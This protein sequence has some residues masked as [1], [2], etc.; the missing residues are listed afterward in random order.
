MCWI[1]YRGEGMIR[2]TRFNGEIYFINAELIQ[3]VEATPDTIITLVNHEKVV[4]RE[5]LSQII[6][7]FI[8]YQRLVRDPNL[9]IKDNGEG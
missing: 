2:V 6:E 8:N 3:S 5:S 9:K 1:F 7:E 4:V